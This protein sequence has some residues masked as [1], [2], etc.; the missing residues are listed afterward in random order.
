MGKGIL[1]SAG[2]MCTAFMTRTGHVLAQDGSTLPYFDDTPQELGDASLASEK[3]WDESDELRQQ[4]QYTVLSE[5]RD[6]DTTGGDITG[7]DFETEEK[8]MTIDESSVD[9][10]TK[11]TNALLD[12]AAVL[13]QSRKGPLSGKSLKSYG[14]SGCAIIVSSGIGAYIMTKRRQSKPKAMPTAITPMNPTKISSPKPH[15]GGGGTILDLELL[16]AEPVPLH[17]SPA[18]RN[19][20]SLELFPEGESQSAINTPLENESTVASESDSGSSMS[21]KVTSTMSKP[22]ISS[23]PQKP[24]SRKN[25]GFGSLFKRVSCNFRCSLSI[26]YV[27]I[28]LQHHFCLCISL[29]TT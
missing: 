10:T 26:L 29:L 11:A 16:D 2:L 4:Q 5:K 24:E 25:L 15:E 28:A 27:P 8:G 20:S 18:V 6:V 19:I 12:E 7:L 9:G 17:Y 1:I 13:Q 21:N 3:F 22:V 14:I 23:S